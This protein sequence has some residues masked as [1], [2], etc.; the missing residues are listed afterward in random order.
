MGDTTRASQFRAT[1][2]STITQH[3]FALVAAGVL[4]TLLGLASVIVPHTLATSTLELIVVLLICSGGITAIQWL[5]GR[6]RGGDQVRGFVPMLVKVIVSVGL[7]YVLWNHW[8][9]SLDLLKTLLC[10]LLIADGTAQILLARRHI[11]VPSRISLFV[12]GGVSC[13][14]A[15]L[16]PIVGPRGTLL[17]WI[18]L[19][20]G[21]KLILF[22]AVLIVIASTA[23]EDNAN[24][25][26]GHCPARDVAMQPGEAYAVYIGNAFHL[27]I[28]VGD[29]KAVDFRNDNLVHYCDVEDFLRGREPQLWEYPDLEVVPPEEVCEFA[30][31]QDGKTI[32]YNFWTFNCEHFAIWCKSGGKVKTSAYAQVA[33]SF[34]T[35]THHPLLGTMLEIYSRFMEWVSFKLGGTFGKRVSRTI[36]S[37]SSTVTK[38]FLTRRALGGIKPTGEVADD[39]GDPPTT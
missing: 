6:I 13:G 2:L 16:A 32:P 21:I 25:V 23:K 7:G 19:L 36:R 5:I 37:L 26:Y 10:I 1:F 17:E 27:G 11:S 29:D 30:I 8:T 22:G 33:V 34:D 35:V 9:L 18:G 28:Y 12:S 31:S 15:I 20:I 14:I 4:I 39:N 38:W 3:R 24:L